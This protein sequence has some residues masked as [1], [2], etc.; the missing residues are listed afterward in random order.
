MFRPKEA[1]IALQEIIVV[2][3]GVAVSQQLPTIRYFMTPLLPSEDARTEYTH[4]E[5]QTE[6]AEVHRNGCP[7]NAGCVSNKRDRK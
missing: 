7:K 1:T 6:E 5:L 4:I 3:R 2:L